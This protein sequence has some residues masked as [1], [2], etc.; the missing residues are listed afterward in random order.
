MVF[1]VPTSTNVPTQGAVVGHNVTVQRRSALCVLA[2]AALLATTRWQYPVLAQ[3]AGTTSVSPTSAVAGSGVP[4]VV[5]ESRGFGHGVGMAQDGALAMAR[6][7]STTSQIL[8]YFYP[9]TVFGVRRGTVRVPLKSHGAITLAFPAGGRVGDVRL[10]AG[11]AI[12]VRAVGDQVVLGAAYTAPTTTLAPPA[13]TGLAAAGTS[14]PVVAFVRIAYRS[15]SAVQAEASPPAVVSAASTTPPTATLPTASSSVVQPAIPTPSN[16]LVPSIPAPAALIPVVSPTSPEVVVSP[17][18]AEPTPADAATSTIAADPA[19]PPSTSANTSTAATTTGATVGVGHVVRASATGG[20]VGLGD[21]HRYRGALELTATGGGLD[22][23]NELDVEDYLRGM[24]EVRDPKWPAAALRAQAIAARTYAYRTIGLHGEVCP[25]E[26]C[27]VYLGAQAEFPEMNAAVAETAGKV[28]LFKGD[29]VHA[30]YSA[31]GGGWT[32]TASEGFGV[33]TQDYPYL[34]ARPY[35]TDDPRVATLRI[36]LT[37][38][39]RR[40]GV[41]DALGVTVTRSGPSGRPIE[42][43]ITGRT[44]LKTVKAAD[45]KKALGLRTTQYTLTTSQVGSLDELPSTTAPPPDDVTDDVPDDVSDGDGVGPLDT[46]AVATIPQTEFGRTDGT[47]P[48]SQQRATTLVIQLGRASATT[49]SLP[50]LASEREIAAAR[51]PVTR[52]DAAGTPGANYDVVLLGG[53]ALALV[54]GLVFAVRRRPTTGRTRRST[55]RRHASPA[56]TRRR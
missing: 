52:S 21:K 37:Q 7:G 33:G 31:S 47:P 40:F 49:T 43:T 23:V 38:L 56:R 46:A 8:A 36:P 16:P 55:T 45:F 17:P 32:A 5:V 53:A 51:V 34:V 9:G 26:R 3:S 44:T 41:N 48:S 19:Q 54:G 11:Q 50:I 29:I 12:T 24:G 27:Q 20:P 22:V 14:S 10:A 39:G 28:L 4:I 1:R 15:P 25:T 30:Y 13:S 35:V 2:V 42:I 18:A 6:R